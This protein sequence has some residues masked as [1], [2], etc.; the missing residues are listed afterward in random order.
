MNI[1]EKLIWYFNTFKLIPFWEYVGNS[2]LILIF[3]YG[4]VM[5]PYKILF[6]LSNYNIVVK[7][8]FFLTILIFLYKYPNFYKN[9]LEVI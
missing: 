5:F 9:N 4:L 2:S 6:Y 3:Y 8:L 7:I 1:K